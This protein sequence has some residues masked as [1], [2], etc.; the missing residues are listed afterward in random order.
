[1]ISIVS[2]LENNQDVIRV[3]STFRCETSLTEK[4]FRLFQFIRV[5]TMI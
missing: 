5:I 4:R 2:R 3:V 1:M